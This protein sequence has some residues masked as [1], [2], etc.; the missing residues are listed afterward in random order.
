MISLS[1][2]H[3]S[4]IGWSA[5]ETESAQQPDAEVSLLLKH[6]RESTTY[7][8]ILYKSPQLC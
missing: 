5:K 8:S 7:F 4:A 3:I 6:E 1:S 2:H